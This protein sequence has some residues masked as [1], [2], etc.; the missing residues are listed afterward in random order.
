MKKE[1]RWS[2]KNGKSTFVLHSWSLF[3]LLL[4]EGQK[5]DNNQIKIEKYPCYCLPVHL[6]F[7]QWGSDSSGSRF[8]MW[9]EIRGIDYGRIKNTMVV[10]WKRRVQELWRCV[11]WGY[12]LAHITLNQK[13]YTSNHVKWCPFP[14]PW[15][16]QSN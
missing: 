13:L 15:W 1:L 3:V 12:S 14:Y 5:C 10:F 11:E 8:S 4:A 7:K 16:P 6:C 2:S 9:N